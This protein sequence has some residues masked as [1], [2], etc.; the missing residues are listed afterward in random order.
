MAKKA[1]ATTSKTT[2]TRAAAVEPAATKV[3]KVKAPAVK[4]ER[5]AAD[6]V[7]VELD[8]K[9]LLLPLSLIISAIIIAVPISLSI[10][11]GLTNSGLRLGGNGIV[12]AEEC[13]TASPL[14]KDCLVSYAKDINLDTAEFSQCLDA[15]TYDADI[16][17]QLNYGNEVGVSGTPTMVIGEDDGDKMRGFNVGA[18]LSLTQVQNLVSRI[19]N[20]GISD[21]AEWWKDQQLGDL[22]TYETQLRDYYSQQGMTGDTLSNAVKNGLDQKKNEVETDT[23]VKEYKYGKGNVR[24]SDDAKAVLMEFSDYECPYCQSFARGAGMQ[25]KDA[26]VDTGKLKFVYMDF[27]LESIHP[28]ARRA[29]L[30]ARCAGAQDKYFEYHD[31]LFSPAE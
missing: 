31:K 20:D 1:K 13:D 28:N 21:A 26:L 29:A 5:K 11:F 9:A 12:Q 19:E 30:A 27:P 15:K 3:E 24:G 25:I 18:G 7:E 2:K 17:E 23:Q 22:S 10:Y 8:T 16:T 14:S 4:A 6:T